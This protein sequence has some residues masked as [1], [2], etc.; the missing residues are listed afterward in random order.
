[1]RSLVVYSS[2]TGNT[3]KVAEAVRE[4]LGPSTELFDVKHAPPP[5]AFDL[6]A[7]GFWVDAGAPDA[8]AREY[9]KQL[10]SGKVALFMT[11]GAL[12]DSDHAREA[13]QSAQTLLRDCE[14]VGT[15]AS[16]GRVDPALIEGLKDIPPQR[17]EMIKAAASHP[18]EEDLRGARETFQRIA[19]SI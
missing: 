14:I 18:D 10:R 9:M 17:R 16:Q 11:L 6:V 13:M 3:R 2:K 8:D 15:F 19:S 4:G 5:D 12:P 1:M 7:L